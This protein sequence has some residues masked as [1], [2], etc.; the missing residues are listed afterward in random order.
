MFKKNKWETLIIFHLLDEG[1][2]MFQDHKRQIY[3]QN[4]IVELKNWENLS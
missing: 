3:P 1:E 4:L 2:K